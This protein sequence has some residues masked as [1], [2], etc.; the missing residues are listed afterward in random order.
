MRH[1]QRRNKGGGL[2][3]FVGGVGRGRACVRDRA[4]EERVRRWGI[5]PRGLRVPRCRQRREIRTP[6]PKGRMMCAW[7]A[8]RQQR[9]SRTR[10]GRASGRG[11]WTKWYA[12]E[13]NSDIPGDATGMRDSGVVSGKT[14]PHMMCAFIVKSLDA[15]N[16]GAP[17][18]KRKGGRS[19]RAAT[20]RRTARRAVPR[21]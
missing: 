9:R 17:R 21:D 6:T 2:G 20:S 16:D 15:G 10:S 4:R 11:A 5:Q 18:S 13:H 8:W 14:R 1:I 19:A 3:V 7:R 12:R